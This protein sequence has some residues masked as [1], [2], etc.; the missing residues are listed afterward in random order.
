MGIVINGPDGEEFTSRS[1][2]SKHHPLRYTVEFGEGRIP[3]LALLQLKGRIS[4]GEV[5]GLEYMSSTPTHPR[6][7]VDKQAPTLNFV[8]SS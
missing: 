1:K 8:F 3:A 7:L 6:F 5:R 4:I 2:I